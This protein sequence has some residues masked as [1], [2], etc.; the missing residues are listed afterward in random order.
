MVV[1][2]S[3]ADEALKDKGMLRD[4]V[5]IT[6]S[7]SCAMAWESQ[8]FFLSTSILFSKLLKM[9][10]ALVCPRLAV[11]CFVVQVIGHAVILLTYMLPV[12]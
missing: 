8:V 6:N 4:H 7:V 9:L 11:E 12:F 10:S 5:A 2:L 1:C 3:N